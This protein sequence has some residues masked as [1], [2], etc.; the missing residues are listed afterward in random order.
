[1]RKP[2][3]ASASVEGSLPPAPLKVPIATVLPRLF[4]SYKTVPLPRE[5][6]TGFSRRKSVVTST[7][8]SAFRGAKRRSATR[9][10]AGSAG[11]T[12]RWIVPE[13]F[14]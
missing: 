8:P 13:S 2:F 11:S 7:M 6:S 14:S 12:R 9:S 1:M 4:T 3:P 10:L 5:R